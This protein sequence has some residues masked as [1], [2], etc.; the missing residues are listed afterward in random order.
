[1][2]NCEQPGVAAQSTVEVRQP[3][4]ISWMVLIPSG[5]FP[6]ACGVASFLVVWLHE[7]LHTQ[8]PQRDGF[9]VSPGVSCQIQASSL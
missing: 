8:K 4:A 2:A 5:K 3:C 9:V 1:M 6:A 7:R